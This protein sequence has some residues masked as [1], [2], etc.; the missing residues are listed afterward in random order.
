MPISLRTNVYSARLETSHYNS[1]L[2]D[3]ILVNLNAEMGQGPWRKVKID[4]DVKT[5]ALKA[6]ILA[7]LTMLHPSNVRIF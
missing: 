5:M 3:H 1:K 7:H 4:F 6:L 2:Y